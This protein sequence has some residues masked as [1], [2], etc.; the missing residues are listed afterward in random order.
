MP[1]AT[2]HGTYALRNDVKMGRSRST[3]ASMLPDPNFPG[4]QH[5]PT[6][7]PIGP[8][9]AQRQVELSPAQAKP[10]IPRQKPPQVPSVVQIPRPSI[11][12]AGSA[13][14]S[15]AETAD[16]IIARNISDA[17]GPG[18]ESTLHLGELYAAA[19]E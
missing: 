2:T 10:D 1:A 3:G 15:D 19:A 5:A 8:G 13:S 12:E 7:P 18:E 16:H 14:G 17:T 4:T 6:S 9:H 11:T